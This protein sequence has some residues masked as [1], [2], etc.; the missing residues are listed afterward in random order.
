M[1]PPLNDKIAFFEHLKAHQYEEQ[2]DALNSDEESYRQ[3]SKSFYSASLPAHVA[4]VTKKPHARL[5]DALHRRTAS[6]PIPQTKNQEL[7]VIAV[8]PLNHKLRPRPSDLQTGTST[9]HETTIAAAKRQPRIPPLRSHSDN[10]PSVRMGGKRK[11]EAPLK[12]VPESRQIFKGL[13]FHYI[14]NDDVNPA[15]RFQ[16]TKAREH[17]ATWCRSLGDATHIVV[18][19]KLAYADIERYLA[20]DP[21]SSQKVL[22]NEDYPIDCI[23]H[24]IIANSEQAQYKVTGTP[25]SSKTTVN[26]QSSSD[27]VSTS[28]EKKLKRINPPKRTRLPLPS[29]PSSTTN[30][31]Q[32]SAESISSLQHAQMRGVTNTTLA[33]EPKIQ[34]ETAQAPDLGDELTQCIYEI[35]NSDPRIP[36]DALMDDDDNGEPGPSHTVDAPEDLSGIDSSD[37]EQPR[38]KR[39]T[40]TGPRPGQKKDVPWQEKFSCMKGGTRD[41]TNDNPNAE[42]IKVLQAMSEQHDLE[43]D[44]FRVRAYRLAIATLREQPRKICTAEEARALPNIDKIADKIEEIV[45]THRLRKLDYALEDPNTATLGLF[46]KIHGVGKGQAR[47]WISKGFRTLDDLR[48]KADLTV[49]QKV[50]LEHFDDLN[51]RIPRREVEALGNYVKKAAAAIDC[52]VELIIGGSYRRGADSSGDIDFIVTKKGTSST[53]ELLPF[54]DQLVRTLSSKG[55]L[56]AALASPRDDDSNKWQGCCVLPRSEFPGPKEEYRPTWR[57]IDF[58]LVPQTE[59]GAALLYFTGNDLFNRSMRLLAKK[60]GMR[61]N[62]QGLFADVLGGPGNIKRTSGHLLE[63]EDEKKIFAILGVRW[64]EPRERWCG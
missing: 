42:T 7:E 31:S 51:M 45:N 23:R 10:S 52:H 20:D 54:M 8:T 63:G 33:P 11:K 36:S 47:K 4:H 3:R 60:K 30:L 62:H 41:Q 12:L 55:F 27:N 39:A 2:D 14:P 58:L 59:I 19:K 21:N 49:N 1:D 17:G 22:V 24:R 61:L 50:G 34:N 18:D 46:R 26:A 56:T 9:V 29:T 15:R 43:G 35:Q 38:K 57:R 37:D 25:G 44:N 32:G 13:S 40:D 28:K 6:D 5:P 64:R 16:I 53:R 48:E